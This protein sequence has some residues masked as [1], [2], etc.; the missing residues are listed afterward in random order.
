MQY[1]VPRSHF[2]ANSMASLVQVFRLLQ[3]RQPLTGFA[4]YMVVQLP[5]N[6]SR[7]TLWTRDG[8]SELIHGRAI[9]TI[10]LSGQLY[11][12]SLITV[13]WSRQISRRPSN[14]LMRHS[15][16]KEATPLPT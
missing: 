11:F 5:M 16:L 13:L 6:Y 9:Q 3:Q 7:L 12:H 8:D 4:K 1:T 15:S 2:P 10:M 14:R